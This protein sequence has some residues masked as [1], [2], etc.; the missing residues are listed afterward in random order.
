M[1]AARAPENRLIPYRLGMF[2]TKQNQM[3]EALES[4][5]KAAALDPQWAFPWLR[6]GLVWS[7]IGQIENAVKALE[8]AYNL[9]PGNYQI[10]SNLASAYAST[11]Q[12]DKALDLLDQLIIDYPDYV[13]GWFNLAL[14]HTRMGQADKA[15]AALEQAAALHHLS[16]D[17]SV[18]IEQLRQ[19]LNQTP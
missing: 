4:F 12:Y 1:A 19:I 15:A 3:N 5:N 6:A 7:R 16:E 2:Q 8:K 11:Q 17:E 10:R 13:N 9:A 14:V 18:R